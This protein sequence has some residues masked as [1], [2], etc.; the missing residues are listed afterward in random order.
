MQSF[1]CQR[2]TSSAD[3]TSHRI[4]DCTKLTLSRNHPHHEALLVS[5]STGGVFTAASPLEFRPTALAPVRGGFGPLLEAVVWDGPVANPPV[6]CTARA[7]SVF[8]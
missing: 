4:L 8:L 2:R 7:Q 3:H 1:A 5:D 6:I